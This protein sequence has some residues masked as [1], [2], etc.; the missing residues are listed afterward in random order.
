METKESKKGK[1]IISR[2]DKGNFILERR[3]VKVEIEKDG[4]KESKV[5]EYDLKLPKTLKDAKEI[6]G[7]ELFLKAGIATLRTDNDDSVRNS[8][9]PE[10]EVKKFASEYKNASEAAKAQIKAILDGKA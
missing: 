9:K 3:G 10:S 5:L 7:E 1:N 6:Y 2:V 4:K 8:G